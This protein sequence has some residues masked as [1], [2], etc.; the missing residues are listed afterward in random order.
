MKPQ[1]KHL[2]LLA[3]TTAG[4]IAAGS[5]LAQ[6][7]STPKTPVP[8]APAAADCPMVG[9]PGAMGRGMQ[10]GMHGGMQGGM[11]HGM[12]G[13]GPGHTHGASFMQRMDTDRD[14]QISRAE[15]EASYQRRLRRLISSRRP[16]SS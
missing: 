16:A 4:V 12:Y 10:G 2:W 14:G 15:I 3:A 1:P 6:S 7:D 13:G 11:R 8:A 5:A 9:G